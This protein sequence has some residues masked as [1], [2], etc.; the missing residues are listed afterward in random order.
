MGRHHRRFPRALRLF[1]AGSR[2]AFTPHPDPLTIWDLLHPAAP[3]PLPTRWW[4]RERGI[5]DRVP[6]SSRDGGC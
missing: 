1:A 6:G 2:G 3:E 4:P 5:N